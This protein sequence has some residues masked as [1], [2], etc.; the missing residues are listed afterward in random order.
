MRG[1]LL[2]TLEGLLAFVD[3]ALS[4]V[5][6]G[7]GFGNKKRCGSCI[8]RCHRALTFQSCIRHEKSG[9]TEYESTQG[10]DRLIGTNFSQSLSDPIPL[11]TRRS[12]ALFRSF[13]VQS[14]SPP[15]TNSISCPL[16]GLA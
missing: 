7:N 9:L 10:K 3:V 5:V 11:M 13:C 15:S 12:F 16:G 8:Q 1:A 2:G 14:V 6:I 4:E